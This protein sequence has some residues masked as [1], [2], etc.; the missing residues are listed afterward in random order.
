VKLQFGT[1]QAAAV[2]EQFARWLPARA[3][4][5]QRIGKR[6]RLGIEVTIAEIKPA[7]SRDQQGY[8]WLSLH[9]FGKWLGYTAHETET[10]LH[11]VI[12]VE[13][14]GQ[15]D[16]REI[17]C[18]GRTYQWPTPKET[19]SKD[20]DGKK[21]DAETYS[22]LIETLIRFAAEQGFVVMPADR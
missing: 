13:T 10:L 21:R 6:A 15:S 9:Q 20:S 18:R 5:F 7:H 1:T 12:C 19:S 3:E 4:Q 17:T 16:T 11:P 8:Y 22:E 2:L 14:W